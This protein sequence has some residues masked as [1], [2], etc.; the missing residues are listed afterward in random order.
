MIVNS[1]SRVNIKFFLL[2]FLVSSRFSSKSSNSELS[3]V[4]ICQGKFVAL[5]VLFDVFELDVLAGVAAHFLFKR[6]FVALEAEHFDVVFES[7]LSRNCDNPRRVKR[8]NA[9]QYGPFSLDIFYAQEVRENI[10]IVLEAR[11][12]FQLHSIIVFIG[13]RNTLIRSPKFMTH[14]LISYGGIGLVS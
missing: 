5:R 3:V 10:R 7:T 14:V 1:K 12:C 6:Q 8:Y 2:Y 11:V 13:D 4:E 9:A